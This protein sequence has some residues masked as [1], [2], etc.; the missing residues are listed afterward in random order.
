MRVELKQV[1][2]RCGRCPSLETLKAKLDRALS[3]SDHGR[4]VGLDELEK[5]LLTQNILYFYLFLFTRQ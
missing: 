2:Q 5:S 3:N 1:A 4:R